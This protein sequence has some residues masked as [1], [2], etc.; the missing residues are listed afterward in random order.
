[1]LGCSTVCPKCQHQFACCVPTPTCCNA[2]RSLH[3]LTGGGLITAFNPSLIPSGPCI[4]PQISPSVPLAFVLPPFAPVQPTMAPV[5]AKPENELHI[6]SE[7]MDT[8]H[9]SGWFYEGI[10]YHQMRESSDS[11][12]LFSLS[13]Q[14]GRGPTSVRIQY[15]SGLFRLDSQPHLQGAMPLFPSVIELVY[16]Y[17]SQP[18]THKNSSQAW[19]DTSGTSYGAILLI[20]PLRKGDSPPS[21]KHLARLSVNKAI[22]AAAMPRL[23][24]LPPSHTQLELPPSLTAYLSEYPYLL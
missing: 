8:L 24:L 20:K 15:I 5:E 2:R 7:T 4:S 16:H 14:T 11:R 6:L 1:M 18:K 22:K 23:P 19:V 9:R 10:T 21:L 13:V 17:V 12:F 3:A